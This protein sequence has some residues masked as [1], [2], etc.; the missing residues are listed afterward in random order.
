M[1]RQTCRSAILC[2]FVM[3]YL[4]SPAFAQGC[5][6]AGF[7]TMGAMKPDQP[8]NKKIELRLRS[9]EISFYRASTTLTPIVYVATAD[10]NFSLNQKTSFQVKLPYQAV[11]GR[12]G[13]TSGMGDISLCFTRN[14]L[15]H[16]KFDVNLSVGGKIPTNHSD[17]RSDENDPLPM[18]YQTSLGSYDF[19]TG[20]SLISKKWLFATGIQ[21]PFN[22]NGNEFVGDWNDEDRLAYVHKYPLAKDLR[23]GTDVM[24]RIERN[25]RFSRLNFSAGLLPIYRINHDEITL[26]DGSR[27]KPDGTT[28]L[29]MSAIATAGYSFNV[30]SGIKLLAGRKITQ[31]DYN[32]DGLT[33]HFVTTISYYYRF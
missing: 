28:G 22:K 21:H 11:S 6:D 31:R 25:F 15:K 8:F 13:N 32:P 16:E 12:L 26:K 5:S 7:C 19:I 4:Y 14:I 9:M 24:V 3:L 29:A 23:R 2:V 10:L 33:R 18:Y 20:I 30:R 1:P 17:K 27:V